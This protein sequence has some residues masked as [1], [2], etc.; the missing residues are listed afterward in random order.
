LRAWNIKSGK[1]VAAVDGVIRDATFA[2]HGRILV[3]SVTQGIDH[4][5]WFC[6]L[7]QPERAPRVVPGRGE[8]FSVVSSP[9][10]S[11]IASSTTAGLVRWFAPQTG[12]LL[13]SVHGHLNAAFGLAFSPDGRRLISASGGRE[14]VKLWDVETEQE[15]LTLS[16]AGSLLLS[17]AWNSDGDVILAGPPWQAWRAPSWEEIAVAEA[18]EKSQRR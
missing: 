17:A 8:S 10:G 18:A 14:S 5:L 3:V 12:E 4:K 11:L 2:E 16:G 15:L 9:D 1:I 13:A 7:A 6:D